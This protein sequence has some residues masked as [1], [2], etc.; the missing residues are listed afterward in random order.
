MV[1]TTRRGTR[2]QQAPERTILQ[3]ER[4]QVAAGMNMDWLP[5]GTRPNLNSRGIVNGGNLCYQS[6]PLQAL[7]HQPPFLQFIS[8]HDPAVCPVDNC[9]KCFL[10]QLVE[11][12]W[13]PTFTYRAIRAADDPH[14]IAVMSHEEPGNR[15]TPNEQEDAHD[16]YTWVLDAL[17]RDA[18]NRDWLPRLHTLYRINIQASDTCRTCGYVTNPPMDTPTTLDVGVLPKYTDIHQAITDT[19]HHDIPG[20]HCRRCRQNR[21]FSRDCEIVAAPKILVVMFRILVYPSKITHPIPCP[22]DLDLT[23]Y[24]QVRTL[25]LRYRLSSLVSHGGGGEDGGHYI[26]TVR[27]Q[28]AG[29]YTCISDAAMMPV[30]HAEFLANPQRPTGLTDYNQLQVYLLSY[31]R[32]DEGRAMPAAPTGRK[33]YKGRLRREL[34]NLM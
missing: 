23:A 14:D 18:P 22:E 11:E 17:S 28:N 12:Y 10:Q 2:A 1:V 15:F 24:Q 34:R 26:A 30:T 19:L 13:G 20:R 33:G 16:F 25:P 27:G 7:L 8:Q 6:A 5:Q 29:T 21:N 9:L 4:D 32:D 3:L 31:I